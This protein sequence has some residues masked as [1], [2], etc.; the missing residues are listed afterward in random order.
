M[1]ALD[2]TATARAVLPSPRAAQSVGIAS[3]GCVCVL[4]DTDIHVRARQRRTNSVSVVVDFSIRFIVNFNSFFYQSLKFR[5]TV[6]LTDSSSRVNVDEFFREKSFSPK[7]R[8]R[9]N[10]ISAAKRTRD[11]L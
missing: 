4:A 1:G 2:R 7:F 10:L 8:V 3:A 6:Y 11:M 5:K 9:E